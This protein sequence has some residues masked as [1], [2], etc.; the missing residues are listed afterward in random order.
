[1]EGLFNPENG[2]YWYHRCMCE[3]RG[4]TE[5]LGEQVGRGGGAGPKTH[6]KETLFFISLW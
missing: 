2:A 5:R 4:T 3:T 6:L 1:M